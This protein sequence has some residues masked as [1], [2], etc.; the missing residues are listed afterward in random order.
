MQKNNP[1]QGDHHLLLTWLIF[2]GA[3]AFALIVSWQQ[4]ILTLLYT[5]DKSRISYAITLLFVLLTGHIIRRVWVI[6]NQANATAQVCDIIKNEKQLTLR[7]TDENVDINGKSNLPPSYATRYIHDLITRYNN[8]AATPDDTHQNNDLIEVYESKLKGPHEI[9]WFVADAMIKLGLLG[10][11]V[12]FILMLG[13]VAD[14]ADFDVTTMQKILRHMSSGMGTAL[15][16]TMAGLVCSML[17]SAQY[18]LLERQIDT[19]IENLKHLTQVY[20]MPRI[21]QTVDAG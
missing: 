1:E 4:G 16:T 8:H 3:M 21:H 20:V 7:V 10:T 2:I 19:M 12:G 14:V 11:I 13:S 5:S 9:G 15:Y 17:V 18:Q 6:S